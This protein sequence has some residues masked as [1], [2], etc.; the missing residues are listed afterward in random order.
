M[1]GTVNYYSETNQLTGSSA[2]TFTQNIAIPNTALIPNSSVIFCECIVLGIQSSAT[3]GARGFAVKLLASFRRDSTGTLVQ[4]GTTTVQYN[5]ID[6]ADTITA[7][8]LQFADNADISVTIT[9]VWT[10]T[11]NYTISARWYTGQ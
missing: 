6:A 9:G 10:H 3:A 11:Y 2:G 1:A 4:I 8:T 7:A 5:Q